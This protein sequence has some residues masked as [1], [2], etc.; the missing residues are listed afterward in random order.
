MRRLAS[1]PEAF[2]GLGRLQVASL[3]NCGLESLPE[4]IGQLASLQLLDVRSNQLK[5]LPGSIGVEILACP[6]PSQGLA[7]QRPLSASQAT[8]CAAAG[9]GR[10]SGVEV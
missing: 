3:A 7:S 8:S 5:C 6:H 10:E 4:A 2:G 9:A 1:L